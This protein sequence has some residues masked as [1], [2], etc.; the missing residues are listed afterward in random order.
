LIL[1]ANKEDKMK[2]ILKSS[3][4]ETKGDIELPSQFHEEIRADLIKRAVFAIQSHKRQ[5]YGTDVLAGM[6]SSSKISRRRRD[7]KTAYGIGISRVPRKIMSYRGTRFNWVAAAVP[8][9]VGG[10]QAHPPQANKIWAKKINDKERKKAIRSAMAASVNKELVQKRGHVVVEYVVVEYP[11]VLE[12][13][14][15]ELS[16]AKDVVALL[17]KLGLEKELERSAKTSQKTGRAKRRGR[18]VQKRIGPLFV[19]SSK[20]VALFN[21]AKN[22]PGI[23]VVDVASL[24]AELLAP[25]TDFGRFTIYTQGAIEK[26]EKEHLFTDKAVAQVIK[27]ETK[28]EKA[29]AAEKPK[30]EASV[31]KPKAE[32]K[33]KEEAKK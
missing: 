17:M 11:F 9:A 24:N 26:L 20:A 29:P 13:G 27:A 3:Q 31:K 15:E 19:V 6:K 4:G 12:A 2:A 8:F 14:V 7:Y 5:P 23:D 10:M 18:T 22:I 25:G 30:K 16:K 33:K 28:K 32:S 1:Q 21:A